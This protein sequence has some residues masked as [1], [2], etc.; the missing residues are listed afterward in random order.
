RLNDSEIEQS[1][2][3]SLPEQIDP[4]EDKFS[5]NQLVNEQTSDLTLASDNTQQI[6]ETFETSSINTAVNNE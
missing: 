5:G 3:Q 4:E 1:S 6:V 2:M